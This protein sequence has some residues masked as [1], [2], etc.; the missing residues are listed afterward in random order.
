MSFYADR[1]L[2]AHWGEQMRFGPGNKLEISMVFQ[3]LNQRQA[4]EVW[5]PFREWLAA[6]PRDFTVEPPLRIVTLP[7]R[8]FWSAAFLKTIAPGAVVADDR[9]HAP[10]GNF[11]WVGDRD[12]VGQVLYAYRSAWLP[13]SLLQEKERPRLVEAL[14]ESTRHWGMSLHFNKGLAGAPR[15]RS[16]PQG[17]PRRTRR[18]SMRSH[19]PSALAGGPPALPGVKG[20]EP[21]LNAAGRAASAV[22]KSMDKL[23][24]VVNEAGSYVSGERFLRV[25]MAAIFLGVKLS[26]VGRREEEIRS[27]RPLHRPSWRWQ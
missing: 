9:P 3:G 23:L 13:V 22:T 16:P 7:A 11:Y 14:F 20:H 5:K 8:S 19:L 1:L 10:A 27:R 21:N 2:N 15:R 26:Q 25:P 6:S 18:C 24:E 12:Q 4:E 17:T